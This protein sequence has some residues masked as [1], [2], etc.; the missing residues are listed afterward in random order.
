MDH[1]D[2]GSEELRSE[3]F[4]YTMP[5]NGPSPS[6]RGG[7]SADSEDTLYHDAGG[8]ESHHGGGAHNGG[9]PVGW[10]SSRRRSSSHTDATPRFENK[11]GGRF[12]FGSEAGG[13]GLPSVPFHDRS[14]RSS[15]KGN[16]LS[17][18]LAKNGGSQ[19]SFNL[20]PETNDDMSE[21]SLPLHALGVQLTP[22][23]NAPSTYSRRDPTRRS[24]QHIGMDGAIQTLPISPAAESHVS[25]ASTMNSHGILSHSEQ[26]PRKY[27]KTEDKRKS[28][29]TA[30][31][32]LP[33]GSG[34]LHSIYS[35]TEHYPTERSKEYD[36][37]DDFD[38]F[39]PIVCCGYDLPVWFSTFVRSIPSLNR[40]SL[41]LVN[42]MP[43][44][45]CCGS[46]IQ[47]SSTDRTVL[48]RLNVV[49]LF[50]TFGQV[51]AS[52]WLASLLLIVD[53]EPGALKGFAPNFW[54][55]NGATFSI[56]ILAFVLIL[57]C[58]YTIRVIKE[59]DLVGVIRS[60]W[61]L[62]W[63]VPFEIFFSISLYDYYN[64]TEV[65]ISHW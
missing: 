22:T 36:T 13:A 2:E 55:L 8:V 40:I 9:T 57:M 35:G 10:P 37:D 32:E 19:V 62:L 46:M 52:M 17:A 27:Q 48:T 14:D 15:G 5:L 23:S 64:V 25:N 58:S 20:D 24:V 56:G 7:R 65:W 4:E 41:F 3:A 60:L 11:A 30:T 44:F 33:L 42:V 54:N 45:W 34:S 47:G 29:F 12:N 26:S 28:Y 39:S 6:P 43:C 1:I 49:C 38:M 63:I 50:V 31:Q 21:P 53:D 18:F 61:V 16:S 59:V 51:V